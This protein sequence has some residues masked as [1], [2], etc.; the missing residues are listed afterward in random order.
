M[1]RILKLYRHYSVLEILLICLCCGL[2]YWSLVQAP[3]GSADAGFVMI[4]SMIAMVL[5]VISLAVQTGV[6]KYLLGYASS[7]KDRAGQGMLVYS[8]ALVW[9]LLSLSRLGLSNFSEQAWMILLYIFLPSIVASLGIKSGLNLLCL[10]RRRAD[11]RL[12]YGYFVVWVIILW[13]HA[14]QNFGV[15]E[16]FY[17]AHRIG[18][19]IFP[20]VYLL[21]RFRHLFL[22]WERISR[23][24]L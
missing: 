20:G 3:W 8:A 13:L 21:V 5:V 4:A 19:T 6:E 18:A 2:Y 17:G 9:V 1:R 12:V 23:S 15:V 14:L 16:M 7:W 24:G 10:F 22:V 11:S